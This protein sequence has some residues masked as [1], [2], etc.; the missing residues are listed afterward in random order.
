ML[1]FLLHHLNVYHSSL[2]TFPQE[3]IRHKLEEEQRQLEIL[4][5]QLLQEQALLM[6][7]SPYYSLIISSSNCRDLHI[8]LLVI[9]YCLKRRAAFFQTK[10]CSVAS[11]L[12]FGF[13]C[14]LNG[15]KVRDEMF[16]FFFLSQSDYKSSAWVC[17]ILH[18]EHLDVNKRFI[19]QNMDVAP[20]VFRVI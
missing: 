12:V 11:L 20:T 8:H 3:F 7:T 5:Q 1:S 2:V 15:I 19:F 17:K 18:V 6:V 14:F 10:H 4:Q 13:R 16:L 9:I